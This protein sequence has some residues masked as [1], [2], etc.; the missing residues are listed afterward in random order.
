[1][2]KKKKKK[3]KKGGSSSRRGEKMVGVEECEESR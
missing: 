1:M 2:I 3:K